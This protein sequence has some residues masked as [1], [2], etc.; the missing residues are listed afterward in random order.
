MKHSLSGACYP[1]RI[2]ASSWLMDL[3]TKMKLVIVSSFRSCS[4]I[5]SWL[6][7]RLGKEIRQGNL[8]KFVPRVSLHRNMSV[9]P[10]Y[11]NCNWRPYWIRIVSTCTSQTIREYLTEQSG[12]FFSSPSLAI[13]IL[14]WSNTV[15]LLFFCL[16][17]IIFSVISFW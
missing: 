12:L 8:E 1:M 16:T 17:V 14:Y 15:S 7:S 6:C 4:Q 10:S 13:F 3:K 11:S 2:F 5:L 9:L